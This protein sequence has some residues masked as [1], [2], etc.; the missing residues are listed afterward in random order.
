MQFDQ[1]AADQEGRIILSLTKDEWLKALEDLAEMKDLIIKNIKFKVEYKD[2]Y[3][4][5]LTKLIGELTPDFLKGENRQS[6]YD[7]GNLVELPTN[8][9]V[10][11]GDSG[12]V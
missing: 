10:I 2:R 4:P 7:A 9:E 12:K 6:Y 3:I 8:Q 11:D 5:L 1:T